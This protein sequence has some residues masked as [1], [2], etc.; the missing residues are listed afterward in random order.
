MSRPRRQ[1]PSLVLAALLAAACGTTGAEPFAYPIAVVGAGASFPIGDWQVTLERAELALGPVY[2]C[3]TAAASPDL[4]AVAQGEFAEVAVV[5]LLAAAPQPIGEVESLAGDVRSAMLDYGISWFTTQTSATAG[6][7][8]GHSARLTGTA[9]RGDVALHFDALIDVLPQLRGSPALV[10]VRARVDDP[11]EGS[12]L[13]L[14]VDPGAWLLG[15]DF[16]ALAAQGQSVEIRPGDP[17]HAAI[18]FALTT[19]PPTFSWTHE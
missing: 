1:H 17:A 16:D 13:L 14:R 10:G 4:C 11:D 6:S 15:L 5:D 3:A 18:A 19:Q 2:L 8:L 7:E 9:I 12:R